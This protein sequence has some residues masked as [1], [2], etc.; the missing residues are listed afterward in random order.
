[1]GINPNQI[2]MRYGKPWYESKEFGQMNEVRIPSADSITLNR[3]MAKGETWGLGFDKEIDERPRI[4]GVLDVDR[5]K[6]DMKD[7]CDQRIIQYLRSGMPMNLSIPFITEEVAENYK[8][9][10][11]AMD[12]ILEKNDEELT[13][14]VVEEWSKETLPRFREHPVGAIPKNRAERKKKSNNEVHK[15]R[16]ISDFSKQLVDGLAINKTMGEFASIELPQGERVHRLI[17]E[18]GNWCDRNGLDRTKL[19]GLKFDVQSAYRI[20][21]IDPADWWAFCYKLVGKRY[22]HKRMPFGITSAVYAFLRIPLLIL[23]FLLTKTNI[24]SLGAFLAM[25]FDD[26]VVIAHESKIEEAGRIIRELFK[27]W[28]IPIQATKWAEENPNGLKGAEEI[29]ILGLEY[30]LPTFSVGIPAHRCAE[31]LEEIE[32]ARESSEKWKLKEAESLVGILSWAACAIPQLKTFLGSSW[33]LLK[34]WNKFQMQRRKLP[35]KIKNDW[36]E[37]ARIMRKF[38]GKQSIL[39]PVWKI[40]KAEGY[41]IKSGTVYPAADASGSIGW[42]V[43]C[44][45]GFAYGVWSDDEKDLKIHLKEGLAL[46]ALI[47]IFGADLT[48]QKWK[49]ILRSDNQALVCA[50]NKGRARDDNLKIIMRL[51]VDE[52]IFQGVALKCWSERNK[53]A[54]DTQFIGTKENTLADCTSRGDVD[55]YFKITNNFH[56][57]KTLQTRRYLPERGLRAWKKAVGEM[58]KNSCM[59]RTPRRARRQR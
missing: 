58:R 5:I 25:Y 56:N 46:F 27:R 33:S 14:R 20:I 6:D 47:S 40:A 19:R 51:I 50:L 59:R 4:E 49:L 3:M 48:R 17:E 38:N 43:A 9:D 52:L 42:G 24:Q 54:V 16:T 13:K 32:F 34:I 37:I 12:K 23:T 15:S 7:Y 29:T 28:N 21:G 8:I 2:S 39:E 44:E 18:A 36:N 31:I 10:E 22:F 45:H 1:M 53:K 55:T 35:D 30:D 26:L 11:N 41:D 57:S